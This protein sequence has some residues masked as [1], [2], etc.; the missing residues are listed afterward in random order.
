MSSTPGAPKEDKTYNTQANG[1]TNDENIGTAR[2]FGEKGGKGLWAGVVARSSG[3][4]GNEK[5]V[6]SCSGKD[7]W[8]EGQDMD[9]KMEDW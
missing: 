9:K 1:G 3:V 5:K 4:W 8:E 7:L 6:C 2:V